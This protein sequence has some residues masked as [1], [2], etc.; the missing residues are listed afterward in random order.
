M[1][2]T[3]FLTFAILLGAPLH[4]AEPVG[5]S[6]P[7]EQFWRHAEFTDV[8]LSPDGKHL[9]ITVPQDDR[10]LLAVIRVADKKIIGKW[11]YGANLHIQNVLWVTNERIVFRVAYKTGSFDFRAPAPD[12]YASDIDG[13][14]RID[15]PNGNTYQV[16]GHVKGQPGWLWVQRSIDQAYLFRLDTSNGRVIT[17]ALA[18]LDGGLGIR[19]GCP[20][21]DQGVH[22]AEGRQQQ[23]EAPHDD[24]GRYPRIADARYPLEATRPADPRQNSTGV[25]HIAQET[26]N[27]REV[28]EGE[29]PRPLG[30]QT[31][32][33]KIDRHQRVPPPGDVG[34]EETAPGEEA[35]CEVDGPVEGMTQHARHATAEDQRHHEHEKNAGEN[36]FKSAEPS[37][38]PDHR[39]KL[40][41]CFYRGL[42][43]SYLLVHPVARLDQVERLIGGLACFPKGLK[44]HVLGDGHTRLGELVPGRRNCGI[45]G[46]GGLLPR[47]TAL[48]DQGSLVVLRQPVEP[49]GAYDLEVDQEDVGGF[50]RVTQNLVEVRC[51]NVRIDE[52]RTVHRPLLQTRVDVTKVHGGWRGPKR[53]HR[54]LPDGRGRRADAQAVEVVGRLH[55]L[56]GKEV[57]EALDPVEADHLDAVVICEAVHPGLYRG[58]V[59]Q[60]EGFIAPRVPVDRIVLVLQEVRARLV[61]KSV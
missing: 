34:A 1:I 3:I 45:D 51:R 23:Q 29:R 39:E 8:R 14:R 33:Q 13:K 54:L 21:P 36:G 26:G 18:P 47:V 61:S 41:E 50:I 43:I 24:T 19:S 42:L 56:V 17:E 48:F 27:D 5:K 49:L 12:M 32:G 44:I 58:R 20:D 53:A 4:A 6:V 9:S 22:L 59:R 55:R 28:D 2:R 60:G 15:I 16:L 57:A 31:I 46:S 52:F 35:G 25:D 11:D 10:T 37:T 7:L 40:P 38:D 30:W